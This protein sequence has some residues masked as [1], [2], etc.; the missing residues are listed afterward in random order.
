[1]D[2]LAS[3]IS[4][5]LREVLIVPDP[6]RALFFLMLLLSPLS[7]FTVVGLS[8][9]TER[10]SPKRKRKVLAAREVRN[11]NPFISIAGPEAPFI[12]DLSGSLL[13]RL[14][15]SL[16]IP[17]TFDPPKYDSSNIARVGYWSSG[18]ARSVL[19]EGD[20]VYVGYGGGIWIFDL[21]EPDSPAVVG[22]ISTPD[23]VLD[24][25]YRDGILYVANS[26]A[27]VTTV[28][29][30]D[31]E[32]PEILDNL[33]PGYD[34]VL[35]V[36][37]WYPYLF[38]KKGDLREHIV[39]LDVSDPRNMEEIGTELEW[40]CEYDVKDG[41]LYKVT[42]GMV[43]VIDVHDP[44]NPVDRGKVIVERM[45]SSNI[46]VSGG[47]AYISRYRGLW[48]IDVHDPDSIYVAG[49]DSTWVNLGKLDVEE[50]YVYVVGPGLTMYDVSDPRNPEALG[51]LPGDANYISAEGGYAYIANTYDSRDF[52]VA[53]C[54][55]PENPEV[56]YE[57]YDGPSSGRDVEVVGDRCYYACCEGGVYILR[58]RPEGKQIKI[59][60]R[61]RE[62][63][64]RIK[65]DSLSNRLYTIGNDS[66]RVYDI[67]DASQPILLGSCY[68]G[69]WSQDV[70]DIEL[71]G[72][73]AL[74]V[75]G[76]KMKAVDVSDPPDPC[77]VGEFDGHGEIAGIEVRD[78]SLVYVWGDIYLY[79]VDVSNWYDPEEVVEY[80][81][82]DWF[83]SYLYKLWKLWKYGDY[84]IMD[85][86]HWVIP[87][88]NP[89]WMTYTVEVFDISD[90]YQIEH[91]MTL[92]Y[93]EPA[94]VAISGSRAC[95][96]SGV[97][98]IYDFSGDPAEWSYLGYYRYNYGKTL[99]RCDYSDGL[100]YVCTNVI[101]LQVLHYQG[102]TVNVS[103]KTRAEGDFLTLSLPSLLRNRKAA[104]ELNVPREGELELDL[105]DVS[106]RKVRE[107]YRGYVPKGSKTAELDFSG[108]KNG[109]YFIG[110]RVS[111]L[112]AS[113]SVLIIE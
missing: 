77:V 28:D 24:M 85:L 74:V 15:P 29:V 111:N 54:R 31:P 51:H 16:S 87:P 83:G 72:D 106:G 92:D 97:I 3:K 10:I 113:A 99:I 26:Y 33:M 57:K 8:G 63:A 38:A 90:I 103:E 32:H 9:N 4:A 93:P 48:V 80:N 41:Y 96:L 22:L 35:K 50:N 46:K 44:A 23:L 39:V 59:L 34:E 52:W 79:V 81:L 43:R 88:H 11:E 86:W 105:Y 47:Y 94:D 84:L 40:G 25:V 101:G 100:M 107:L 1:M 42:P 5:K 89:P 53:D 73:K 19:A 2:I 55:N 104:I 61:I 109:V 69:G 6:K 56:V 82:Q 102:D 76:G 45:G 58:K 78:D 17:G 68:V 21:S 66:F 65:V 14:T 12:E 62:G 75:A 67:G 20:Y 112:K 7:A 71:I 37:L 30:S 98:G 18:P 60:G 108:L 70:A 110:G 13:A 64:I 27:G 91:L 49:V 95:W 36:R